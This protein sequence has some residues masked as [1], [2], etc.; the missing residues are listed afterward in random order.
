MRGWPVGEKKLKFW[1]FV[2]EPK[3]QNMI[4]KAHKNK[5]KSKRWALYLQNWASYGTF[6]DATWGK[7]LYQ[8]RFSN[9]GQFLKF[10]SNFC[11]WAQFLDRSNCKQ[12]SKQTSMHV[13]GDESDQV[14]LFLSSGYLLVRVKVVASR[15]NLKLSKTQFQFRFQYELSLA[16]LSTGFF[17]F[18]LKPSFREILN[19]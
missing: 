15:V 7:N 18:I 12:A 9:L 6:C 13:S 1:K 16:K 19:I 17:S 14:L 2:G 11:K 5:A 4:F 3:L 8:A 10:G